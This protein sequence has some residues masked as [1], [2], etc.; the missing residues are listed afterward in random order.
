MVIPEER[1]GRDETNLD[2]VR[3]VAPAA[4]STDTRKAG[5]GLSSLGDYFGRKSQIGSI[6][7][8]CGEGDP[9]SFLTQLDSLPGAPILYGSSPRRPCRPPAQ[10][11]EWSKGNLWKAG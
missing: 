4:A 1:E 3:D 6:C 11:D 8:K 2:L 7:R 9:A 5:K 10:P